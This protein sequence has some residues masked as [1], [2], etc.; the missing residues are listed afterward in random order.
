MDIQTLVG[1]LNALLKNGKEQIERLLQ[2][3]GMIR[4]DNGLQGSEL[5]KELEIA[6]ERPVP[7]FPRVGQG[8]FPER[9]P[10]ANGLS[11]RLMK[12]WRVAP[13]A[14]DDKEIR[15]AM[16]RPQDLYLREVLK[17]IY[18]RPVTPFLA[19]E[20]DILA[21]IYRWYEAEIDLGGEDDDD[22]ESKIKEGLWDDPEQLRDLASEAPV[23]R[24]VNHI[25]S[26]ALEV[27]ASDIHF[28]PFRDHLTIRFRIDGILHNVETVSKKL[29]PAITSRLKLMAKM[30][31]AEMRLPQDGR[32]KV[33]EGQREIDIRVSSLPTLFGESIVLR[34]LNREEVKLDLTSLGLSDGLLK[35]FEGVIT[36]PYGMVLVTGPT[37][38]G[39]T[40]TLYAVMNRI[41][42]PEKKIVT[43]E[44]PVEYQLDGI[45]QIHV[46]SNI[47][48]TFTSALRTILRQDPDVILI[49]EIRDAETA[50]IAVQSALTGHMVFS[51]LHTN[52]AAS[53]ITRLQEMG[54][55][56]YLLSSCILAVM[57]QR[58][59]RKICQECREP[60][61]LP[62][63]FADEIA[64][65]LGVD[66]SQCPANVWRGAG[67][68]RCAGT[69]Y[70]GRTG[71]YEFLLIDDEIRRLIMQR[72]DSSVIL[73]S[74]T[75]R[76]M[77]TLRQ[78]GFQKVI[79]GQTTIEEVMRVTN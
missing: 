75:Q 74:A 64:H 52:D 56:S 15:L 79:E 26:Q 43:V 46:R 1:P 19:S 35:T 42:S 30:N 61:A 33:R 49:G 78:D 22:L 62:P 68:A 41:N 34:L 29:Q 25:I 9:P 10:F 44:D 73:A 17:D 2:K 16:A 12:Q 55:E 14:M 21:A 27:K 13:L 5:E 39:K 37:G 18:Q 7:D 4:V 51:T 6:D 69:G 63:G 47:G 23:I 40:T 31:I 48:L 20:E 57:A 53:A 45:N 54:V 58:L 3:S 28:E 50:E 77:R 38:S 76:G 24:L 71:I 32:I 67:C 11:P 59:V 72:A 8:D 60:Y 70:S 65:C 66:V 36:R